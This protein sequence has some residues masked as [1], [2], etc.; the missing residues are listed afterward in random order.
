MRAIARWLT[1]EFSIYS[2]AIRSNGQPERT[3]V[4]EQTS[5]LPIV[6]V[7][8][9]ILGAPITESGGVSLLVSE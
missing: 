7:A 8:Q 3:I 6:Y 9:W 5:S 2:R 4:I 1:L